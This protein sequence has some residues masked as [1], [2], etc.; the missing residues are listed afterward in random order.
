MTWI[1]RASPC[2]AL[3]LGLGLLALALLAPRA[4]AVTWTEIPSGT[5][6][7]ITAIEYQGADRLWFGTGGGRVFRRVGGTFQQE[8]FV[9]G[10]V[11]KDIEFQDGG[12]VG[13]A[14][15]T[16]GTVL[17]S[18]DG[19][20]TWRAITGIAGGRQTDQNVCN[21]VDQ[22]IGDV[23]SI[24]FADNARA[25]LLAGGSQVYR[26]VNAATASDVGSTAAGWIWI[27]DNG[28]DCRIR[29]DVDDVFPLPGTDAAY[30]VAKSFGAIFFT[31][32]ALAS[33]A[34]EKLG[35]AGNGF[36]T[37]RRLAG[38][39]GNPNRMW[40]VAPNGEGNT[41]FART[42]DGW[43]SASE[44]TIAN[45]D[46][47]TLTEGESVDFNGGTVL[48][49]GS[50][51][52]ILASIDG[53]SFYFEPAG[54][55]LA[56]QDWL[57]VGLASAGDAAIGGTGGKLVISTDAGAL[58]NSAP[59]SD[60]GTRPRVPGRKLPRVR[61]PRTAPVSGGVA[62]VRGRFVRVPVS[63]RITPPRSVGAAA[64]CRG[65]RVSLR[66][67]R[68]RGR[69][70]TLVR[71]TVRVSRHCRYRKLLRVR[72]SRVGSARALLLQVAFRGNSRVGASRATYTIP[73]AR[74]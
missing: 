49:A 74:G 51:G 37:T 19:G 59:P 16:S 67:S 42:T 46:S 58:P 60:T 40:S 36:T 71:T 32:D 64:A 47:G 22:G 9:P 33:T 72:R 62:K 26:T 53:A 4:H 69:R 17:R 43:N 3:A 21:G 63:G 55:A 35:S 31:S 1:R 66:L 10:A 68:T 70:R 24:R 6:E 73:V 28:V 8:A 41:F 15:G 61:F 39:P 27:N 38:D 25:W 29:L 50:A 57:G 18:A 65:R 13:F 7:D 45:P 52:L 30:F 54:G 23:E 20:D 12:Q 11:I 44:W 5:S 34:S 14:V 48:A 56:G 2:F